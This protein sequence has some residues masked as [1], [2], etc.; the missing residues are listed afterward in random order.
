MS[1]SGPYVGWILCS[2]YIALHHSYTFCMGIT[3]LHKAF[4]AEQPVKSHRW[5][6]GVG[7]TSTSLHPIPVCHHLKKRSRPC[8]AFG[9]RPY[10]LPLQEWA[11]AGRRIIFHP[12]AQP[13]GW[14]RG[15]SSL[16]GLQNCARLHTAVVRQGPWA[17]KIVCGCTPL[18]CAR[19]S[20][21]LAASAAA[22]PG[23]SRCAAGTL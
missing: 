5:Q 17:S 2:Q 10:R 8:P 21:N 3:F 20:R 9:L 15:L 6:A 23:S 11:G 12:E 16:L 4:R 14:S 7:A 19:L 13:L 18:L 22:T 1:S